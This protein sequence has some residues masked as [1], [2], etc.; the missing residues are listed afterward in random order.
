MTLSY[1]K[2]D[3]LPRASS[4]EESLPERVRAWIR[5]DDA[6]ARF[7]QASSQV[8]RAIARMNEMREVSSESLHRPIKLG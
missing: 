8:D 6:L 5:S 3:Q 4:P 1:S 2:A 7:E